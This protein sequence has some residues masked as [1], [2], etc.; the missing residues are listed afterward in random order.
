M[1]A[2]AFCAETHPFDDATL[3][4]RLD[5]HP[6][7]HAAGEDDVWDD[8]GDCP[9]CTTPPEMAFDLPWPAARWSLNAPAGVTDPADG[10]EH[11]R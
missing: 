10:T 4:R 2:A 7:P 9:I 5:G 1:T 11:H 8:H 6:G 3:C